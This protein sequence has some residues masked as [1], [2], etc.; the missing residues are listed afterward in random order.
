MNQDDVRDGKGISRRHGLRE[1][2]RDGGK[3]KESRKEKS[4]PVTEWGSHAENILSDTE[5][6]KTEF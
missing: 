2:E 5:Y 6:R 1:R 3:K 4:E